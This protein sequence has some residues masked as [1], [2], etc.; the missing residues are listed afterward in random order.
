MAILHKNE[1]FL[2]E[3]SSYENVPL[4]VSLWASD[5]LWTSNGCLYEVLT[6]CEVLTS[7]AH[8]ATFI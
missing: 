2:K 7:D 4:H 6:L 3:T 8:W 1:A 5:V